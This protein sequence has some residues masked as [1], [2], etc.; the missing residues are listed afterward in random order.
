MSRTCLLNFE[1]TTAGPDSGPRAHGPGPSPPAGSAPSLFWK[2]GQSEPLSFQLIRPRLGLDLVDSPSASAEP[3]P[4][5][6]SPLTA[7]AEHRGRR[8]LCRQVTATELVA[9]A[10]GR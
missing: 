5:P 9:R 8:R 7:P 3:E 2:V 4:G 1:L 6:V 10:L